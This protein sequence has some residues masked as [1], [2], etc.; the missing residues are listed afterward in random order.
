MAL[1]RARE[2]T[3]AARGEAKGP[4]PRPSP[5]NRLRREAGLLL[6]GPLPRARR[7]RP[8]LMNCS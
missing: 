1:P 3:E 2:E 8:L 6:K 7:G 5:Q 4:V